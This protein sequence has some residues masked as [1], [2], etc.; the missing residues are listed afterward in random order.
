MYA[1]KTPVPTSLRLTRTFAAPREE[2]FRAWVEPQALKSWFAP[3]DGFE[4]P[5]GPG[6]IGPRRKKH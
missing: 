6:K 3:S 2:V 4:T 1:S 5:V